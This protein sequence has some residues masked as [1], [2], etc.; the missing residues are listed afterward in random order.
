VSVKVVAVCAL[1]VALVVVLQLILPGLAE[2]RLRGNLERNARG[3]DVH[4]SAFPAV[5][6]LLHRADA[7]DVRIHEAWTGDGD[8]G[9]M[10]ASTGDAD[11]VDVSVERMA[12]LGLD[13]E[14]VTL[15]KT[16]DDRL[17][18]S[19]SVSPQALREALPG[20]LR[21]APLSES[22]G[23]VVVRADASVLGREGS[24]RLRVRATRGAVV[25]APDSMLGRL[26]SITVF[27]DPRIEVQSVT[28]RVR[29]GSFVFTATGRLT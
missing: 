14:S 29:G 5:K 21:L 27:E 4:V 18:A 24:L 28:S 13:L 16:G 25:V 1:A 11:R 10:L 19:A 26:A 8:L 15:R 17:R 20:W 6:L 12:P 22:A 23:G 7:V 2:R 3:V 9:D